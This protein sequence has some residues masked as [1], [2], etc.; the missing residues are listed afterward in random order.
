M[1]GGGPLAMSS[2]FPKQLRRRLRRHRALPYGFESSR[3]TLE[4]FIRFNAEQNVI[5]QAV[6]AEKLFVPETLSLS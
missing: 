6:A 5:P 2:R 3:Q 1:A 4:T